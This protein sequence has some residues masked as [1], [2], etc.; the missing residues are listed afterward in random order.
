M[1][2]CSFS[3]YIVLLIRNNKYM[4]ASLERY[5]A[6]QLVFALVEFDLK[7]GKRLSNTL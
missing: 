4:R 7:S 6:M 3:R 2:S 1:A 5:Q